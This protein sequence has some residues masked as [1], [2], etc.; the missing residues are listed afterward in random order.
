MDTDL[1]YFDDEWSGRFHCI[2]WVVLKEDIE[3]DLMNAYLGQ[4][5]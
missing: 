5:I 2:L 3:G 4:V 1:G